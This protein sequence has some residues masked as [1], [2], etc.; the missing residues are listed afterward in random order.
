MPVPGPREV[1]IQVVACGVGYVDSLVSLGRYQVKPALPHTP[2]QEVGGR[3]A[4]VGAQVEGLAI[5]DRVMARVS[6]GFAQYVRA[7][8]SDVK[9][10]PAAMSEAQAAGGGIIQ[11]WGEGRLLSS[12][13]LLSYSAPLLCVVS[14]GPARPGASVPARNPILLPPSPSP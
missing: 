4:A 8:V 11:G 10:I 12:P 14:P 13:P 3:I 9:A 7:A 6:G 5:G 1:L 2:G